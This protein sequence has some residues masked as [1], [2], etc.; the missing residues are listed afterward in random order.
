MEIKVVG[1][2]A[3][4][5]NMGFASAT[6]TVVKRLAGSGFITSI[7]VTALDLVTT[8]AEDRKV[9][10]KSSIDLGRARVLHAA[11]LQH[12]QAVR[13]AFAEVP[14]GSQS[15]AAARCL[16]I[17]TGVLAAC[18]IPLI[19]VSPMEVKMAV[20]GS[21]KIKATK[22][23][24]IAWAVNIWPQAPW[25]RAATGKKQ[26]VNA[27]EH[28]AD[29]L[30]TIA[31]GVATLEFQRVIAMMDLPNEISST[32]NLGSSPNSA[33]RRRVSVG[34]FPVARKTLQSGKG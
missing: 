33:T 8:E 24:I 13:L 2:D 18:P 25:L 11:L 7:H 14:S 32:P 23:D 30:A 10:R 4:F 5:T 9:V 1:I 28:L 31:A 26:I 3:A 29:A 20:T 16:G 6:L 12:T 19:E 27:N 15:A 34:A 22:A 21:R 17:A